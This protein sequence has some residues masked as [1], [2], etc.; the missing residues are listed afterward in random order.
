MKKL[1]LYL[2]SAAALLLGSCSDDKELDDSHF[3]AFELNVN[4]T[5]Y[6]ASIADNTITITAP[7][8]V[9]LTHAKVTYQLSEKATVIPDPTTIEDWSQDQ[10]F[11]VQSQSGE[12]V[13]YRY[14][15]S[16]SDVLEANSV[17]LTTQADV[18]NFAKKNINHI[19]GNLIIGSPAATSDSIKNLDGLKSV[20][21][22]DY[23]VVV[24]SSY[25]GS[26]LAGLTNLKYANGLYI[27]SENSSVSFSKKLAVELP[28]LTESS[29]IVVHSDSVY[30]VSLPTLTAS[31]NIYINS[32][33]LNNLDLTSYAQCY[34]NFTLKGMSSNDYSSAHS[35]LVLATLSLPA[36]KQVNGTLLIEN[37]WNISK[38]S[39]PQ[40]EEVD[41][42]LQLKYVRGTK[43]IALP[44]LTTV[45][46]NTNIQ[47]NDGMTSFAAPLLASTKSLNISSFNQ[48]SINLKR[49]DLSALTSVTTTLT[50][51][52][53]GF[54]DLSTAQATNCRKQINAECGRLYG[55]IIIARTTEMS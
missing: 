48:Y 39:M 30:S 44:A 19:Q 23:N 51:Q 49:I 32:I 28:A 20:T 2:F 13:S 55:D 17:M 18:D 9:D 6:T 37:F 22:V 29:N 35:N 36:L 25:A 50:V 54:T 45:K 8:D 33:E 31:N 11:R 15:T 5:T 42:D 52:Y 34:G 12:Y 3:V 10:A 26:N 53:G 46:N 38:F 43:K 21:H 4:N 41:G 40:L 16:R 47:A 24:N 27:G 1:L 7:K 14:T